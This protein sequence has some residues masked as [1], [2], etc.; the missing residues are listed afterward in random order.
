[1]N[2]PARRHAPELLFLRSAEPLFLINN[3][4]AEILESHSFARECMRCDNNPDRTVGETLL[5]YPCL[6]RLYKAREMHNLDSKSREAPLE[7]SQML[8]G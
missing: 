5:D 6:G 8:P 3:E 7:G 2:M 4:K 1:M